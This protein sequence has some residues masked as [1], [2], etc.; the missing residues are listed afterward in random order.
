MSTATIGITAQID[1]AMRRAFSEASVRLHPDCRITD[2]VEALRV[3]GISAEITDGVLVLAQGSTQMN[4]SLAL[5]NFANRPEHA[6]LFILENAHP[7][8]WTQAHKVEF[9]RTHS[10]LEYGTLLHQPVLEAGIRVLDPNMSR[11]DYK[12]LTRAEKMAF[13]REF[14]SDAAG[15]IM[16]GKTK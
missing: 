12:N 11:T 5:R 9:M 16:L 13:I 2:I 15:R 8:T 3:L 14:G 10:D 1:T 7:S 6:R 4:F